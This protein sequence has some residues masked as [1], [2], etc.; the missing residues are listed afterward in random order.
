MTQKK[1]I[2]PEQHELE[3]KDCCGEPEGCE[4]P[5]E[6]LPE[7]EHAPESHQEPVE[8]T[9]PLPKVKSY[10]VVSGDSYASLGKRFRPEGTSSHQ[11]ALHLIALN[12]NKPLNPGTI[13]QL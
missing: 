5:C 4:E 12:N 10:E 13:I 9:D 7:P 6:S 1:Q 3:L 11:H 8:A 2:E